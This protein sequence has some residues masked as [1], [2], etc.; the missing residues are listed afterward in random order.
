MIATTQSLQEEVAGQPSLLKELHTYRKVRGVIGICHCPAVA[1]LDA[2]YAR[3]EQIC[4]C[5]RSW[6]CGLLLLHWLLSAVLAAAAP[7]PVA[8]HKYRSNGQQ[9]QLQPERKAAVPS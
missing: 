1:D 9:L 4:R 5:A 6:H 8:T 2:A 7:A 3:F